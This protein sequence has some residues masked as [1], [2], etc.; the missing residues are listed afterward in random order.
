MKES[1]NILGWL[2]VAAEQ[3]IILDAEKHVDETCRTVALLAEAMK[4]FIAGDLGAKTV[5][6]ENVKQ[7]ERQADRIRARMINQLSE[8]MLLP[9]HREDL[10]RFA[11]ALDRIAD[12]TNKAARLLGLIEERLPDNVLKNMTIS[13]EL[14]VNAVASLRQAIHAMG[15][16]DAPRVLDNCNEVERFEHEADDQKRTFLDIVLHASLTPASLLLCYNLA[17][18]LEEITDRID[19]AADM[20]RLLAVRSS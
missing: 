15:K 6:I 17:E 8:G 4:A 14:I 7:S 20:I 2:G 13:T 12:C 18:A 16:N 10:M 1:R 3:T 5:A 19:S 11:K 9:P